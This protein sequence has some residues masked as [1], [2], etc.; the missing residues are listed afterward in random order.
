MNEIADD[1]RLVAR[2]TQCVS[3]HAAA[4]AKRTATSGRAHVIQ[5]STLGAI[6]TD[7]VFD[8]TSDIPLTCAAA[9]AA[10]LCLGCAPACKQLCLGSDR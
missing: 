6:R 7:K 8:A 5:A 3:A 4:S 10:S 9:A 1:V 2:L